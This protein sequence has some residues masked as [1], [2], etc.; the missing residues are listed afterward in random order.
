[1]LQALAAEEH[2]DHRRLQVVIADAAGHRPEVLEGQDVALE[3]GLLGL[4]GEGHVEAPARVAEA[5]AEHP[6]HAAA[7]RDLPT[8]PLALAALLGLA[9]YGAA[10]VIWPFTAHTRCHGT[11]KRRS[12]SGKAWRTCRGCGGT[13][14]KVRTGRRLWGAVTTRTDPTR[15]RP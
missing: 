5:Q 13:G 7:A 10:C 11:G 12:P 1:M 4:V 6:Q 9:L 3:E 14:R 2:L 15:R 8:G